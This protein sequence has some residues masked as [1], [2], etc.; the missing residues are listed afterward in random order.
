MLIIIFL[1]IDINV[2]LIP[3]FLYLNFG[4]LLQANNDELGFIV[5]NEILV[6]YVNE[7]TFP[8]IYIILYFLKTICQR[9]ENT[10]FGL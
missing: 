4:I 2:V 9:K 7:I 6:T 3:S 10:E 5:R 8:K 1:M